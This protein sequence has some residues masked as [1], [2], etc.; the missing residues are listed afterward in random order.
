MAIRGEGEFLASNS[1]IELIYEIFLNVTPLVTFTF[2]KKKS[3]KRIILL[4]KQKL[5]VANKTLK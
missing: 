5:N 4:E 2:G 3:K 1:Q